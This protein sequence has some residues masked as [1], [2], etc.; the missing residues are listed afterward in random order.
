MPIVNRSYY[1]AA[2][3]GRQDRDAAQARA[4][5]NAMSQITI[6]RERDVNALMKNPNATAEQYARAGQTGI[7]NALLDNQQVA[8]QG[9]QLDAQRLFQAAQYGMQ[10]QSPKAFIAQNY[11][12]IAAL[13]PNFAQES[14]E[15]V[16]TSLQELLGKFG[17]QAGIGPA[18]PPVK[19]ERL[20]GPR[21]SV[22]QRDPRTGE[23]KQVVGP[24]NTQPSA[25]TRGRY[26]PL[27]A[28]E[29][30]EAGLPAGSSAQIDTETGKIDIL[31]KRDNSGAISQK[32]ATTAKQKLVTVSLAR[33]QLERIKQRF[34]GIKGTM[35][36]GAFGQGNLPTEG[37]KSFDAAV[38]QMRSTLTALTRTPGV[39]AMS[40]YETKLD[41][42]KFP[43]RTNYESVTAEQIQAIDDQLTLIERGY[44]G[45]LE[46]GTQQGGAP[47]NTS[48]VNQPVRVNSPQEAMALPSGTV[49]ITPDGRQKVR[50]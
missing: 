30:H 5:H 36:A 4:A 37:G 26:R 43:A 27:S 16:R 31:S 23:M 11:P 15:T 3:K 44:R 13:N 32:D 38:D 49:F 7:S 21:G 17:P 2:E 20:E 19:Y 29:I 28:Q 42:A 24:D 48:G 9:K 22:L 35:A 33:Q 1:D 50:P 18:P 40:D 47:V 6:D 12:E 45:L 39:G 25:P 14:D 41:Q 10:S 46:G 34:E 8:R